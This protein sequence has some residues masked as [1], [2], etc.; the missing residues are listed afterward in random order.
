MIQNKSATQP[1]QRNE[2][3]DPATQ[4]ERAVTAYDDRF[5]NVSGASI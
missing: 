1:I 4:R 3:S 5:I 2:M